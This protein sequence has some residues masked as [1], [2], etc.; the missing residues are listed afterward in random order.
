[1]FVYLLYLNTLGSP[2]EFDANANAVA[3]E[4]LKIENEGFERDIEVGEPS[5]PTLA[6]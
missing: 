1:M 5:E 6:G 4:R 3:I 2:R